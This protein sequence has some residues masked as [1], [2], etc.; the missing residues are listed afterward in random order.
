MEVI[1]ALYTDQQCKIIITTLHHLQTDWNI[2][3]WQNSQMPGL[4]RM[5][6]ENKRQVFQLP[7]RFLQTLTWEIS[8]KRKHT[9]SS[10]NWRASSFNLVIP[11]ELAIV[12][13]LSTAI[14]LSPSES[15]L[16]WELILSV[17]F[18][19]GKYISQFT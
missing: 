6:L 15:P 5:Q 9:S 1:P 8:L 12:L 3:K 16:S 18:R 14:P 13:M 10:K 2:K 17:N 7:T 19:F 11:Y 4:K